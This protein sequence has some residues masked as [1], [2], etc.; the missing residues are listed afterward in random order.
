[1]K[2]VKRKTILLPALIL[3]CIGFNSTEDPMD[4]MINAFYNYQENQ[5]EKKLYLHLDKYMYRPGEDIWFKVYL[6][7]NA[8]Q[9]V[10]REEKI[11]LELVGNNTSANVKKTVFVNN[12]IAF[13]NIGIPK[14]LVGGS[15]QL[16]AY[17]KT[18]NTEV[19]NVLFESN[20]A[21]VDYG[22][23]GQKSTA[24]FDSLS[25]S[26]GDVVRVDIGTSS[27][28]TATGHKFKYEASACTKIFKKG[29][30]NTENGAAKLEFTLPN[31]IQSC[32]CT[33]TVT[34]YLSDGKTVHNVH[35]V[36][37]KERFIDLQFFP[38]GG[39]IVLGLENKIAY[40]AVDQYGTPIDFDGF[41]MDQSTGRK[42]RI[43]STYKGM[44][45]FKF[46]P[47]HELY[48]VEIVEPVGVKRQY[49]LP[50]FEKS[51]ML[52][53]V[54]NVGKDNISIELQS[55]NVEDERVYLA[56]MGG[57]ELHWLSEE[58]VH[59][60]LS[61]EIP[62]KDLHI[63]I[64]QITLFNDRLEPM[65]E[66]LVFVNE[67]RKLT[68]DIETEKQ[69]YGPR[70]K[71]IAR[72][73]VWDE[74]GLPV[75][76]NLSIAVS[77]AD[78][79]TQ[80]AYF[81][82]NLM[83]QLLLQSEL[84]GSIPTPNY[85]FQYDSPFAAESL[86]LVMMTHGWRRYDWDQIRNFTGPK[87]EVGEYA[88]PETVKGSVTLRNGKPAKRRQV[89]ILNAN[90]MSIMDIVETDEYG[91]FEYMFEQ[92]SQSEN[93]IWLLAE[94]ERDEPLNIHTEPRKNSKNHFANI[95]PRTAEDRMVMN[96][97]LSKMD[98]EKW[99]HYDNAK[100]LENVTIKGKKITP[101]EIPESPSE[102]KQYTRKKITREE[103]NKSVRD[104]LLD[105][106]RLV[107]PT[108]SYDLLTGAINLRRAFR[109]ITAPAHFVINDMPYGS[110]YW[111]VNQINL[112]A[113]ESIEI[114]KASGAGVRYGLPALGGLI[115]IT[116][117]EK[118]NFDQQQ[119]KNRLHN[120]VLFG[121]LTTNKDFYMPNYESED[122]PEYLGP[123][124]RTTI[125]WEPMVTTDD[126]G[127]AFVYFYNGELGGEVIGTLEG[128]SLDGRIG[129]G[130]FSYTVQ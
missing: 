57:D 68:V 87:I 37:L 61:L 34:T 11:E 40:K 60:R 80:N 52:M 117:K 38:E 123:D 91:Q 6:V 73:N 114:V 44:G 119:S 39:N 71:V 42:T 126:N 70:E 1:M 82:P 101:F 110:Q 27:F 120:P 116:T 5:T 47:T 14:D 109:P 93:G 85:Y 74:K 105:L 43:T 122:T 17:A 64:A 121:A 118:T 50:T 69:F 76:A 54:G 30:G 2:T 56:I 86:D 66:R 62:K 78:L 3:L 84:R 88:L 99:M 104:N 35:A 92:T 96:S 127:E 128:L 18:S 113:I 98:K 24:T 25:Y 83:S 89:H 115:I 13:G 112:E 129:H 20:I 12:G 29:S 106:I 63:G 48:H 97:R 26:P 111:R 31:D 21:V 28:G 103:L 67:H 49:G 95:K 41:I 23:I 108:A 10:K 22:L 51:G 130:V 94:S 124:L 125:H 46:T 55:T 102:L 58:V 77:N 59:D 7:D 90:D 45:A 9:L 36:P 100:L 107:A 4:E 15:Y 65:Q 81:K 8:L 79:S 16:I 72:I 33:L 32:P 19:S 53:K 75:R